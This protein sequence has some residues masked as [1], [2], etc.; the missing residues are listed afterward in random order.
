MT[1]SQ[2][3]EKYFCICVGKAQ[4]AL[5]EHTLERLRR[6]QSE[7]IFFVKSRVKVTL[8]VKSL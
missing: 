7:K 6:R 2:R 8:S 3:F 5:S 1:V 4:A